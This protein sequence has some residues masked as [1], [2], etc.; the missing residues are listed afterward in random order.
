VKGPDIPLK[1]PSS[2]FVEPNST[3]SIQM[4]KEAVGALKPPFAITLKQKKSMRVPK[5][6]QLKW[7]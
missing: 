3:S 7:V 4:A 6:K 5:F 2:V 1:F